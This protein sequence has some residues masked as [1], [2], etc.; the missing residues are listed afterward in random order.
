MK[1]MKLAAL[2]AGVCLSAGSFAASQ[3]LAET[4]Q[5]VTKYVT[6]DGDVV[7]YEPG[8]VIV[9]RSSDNSEAT[10]TLSSKA[11][12]PTE[13]KVGR[14]VTLYTEPGSDGK[15]QL[16]SRVT[17]TAVTPEGKISRTTEETRHLPSGMTTRTTTARV[18]GTVAAYEAG[19]T[20]TL[21][22][23]DGSKVTYALNEQSQV[24]AGLVLGKTVSILPLETS[25]TNEPV[26]QTITYV[27]TTTETI[28]NN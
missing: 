6:V 11:V 8:H 9:I 21:T 17:T 26:A 27:T 4:T 10:Y 13:V 25:D 19:R 12:L 1:N 16:V 15:T 20:L 18:S 23:A 24:P 2:I 3:A 28:P 22:R 5:T 7:R 14:R